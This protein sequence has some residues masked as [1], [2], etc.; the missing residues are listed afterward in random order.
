MVFKEKTRNSNNN[1]WYIVDNFLVTLK[2]N[3]Y[4]HKLKKVFC[5]NYVDEV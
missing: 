4:Q 2:N 5:Y 1:A 3:T